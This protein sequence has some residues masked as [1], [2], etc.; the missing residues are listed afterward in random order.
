MNWYNIIKISFPIIETKPYGYTNFGHKDEDYE[1]E[2][3]SLWTI[4]TSFNFRIYNITLSS[5]TELGISGHIDIPG[6]EENKYI[7]QGRYD[8][9]QNKTSLTFDFYNTIGNI[10]LHAKEKI[11]EKVIKIIDNKLNNPGIIE[12]SPS[13]IWR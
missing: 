4:D 12:T 1:E 2:Y 6:Y 13:H 11:K 7:A 5:E 10:S 8:S 9:K 3:I